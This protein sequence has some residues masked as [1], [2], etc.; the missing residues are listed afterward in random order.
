MCCNA[1]IRLSSVNA[2]IEASS[3][4]IQTAVPAWDLRSYKHRVA[5]CYATAC[6]I[7]NITQAAVE[8]G[9][10]LLNKSMGCP[11]V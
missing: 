10:S 4:K 8:D 11:G 3:R 5:Q 7:L 9:K 2:K 6:C 1:L